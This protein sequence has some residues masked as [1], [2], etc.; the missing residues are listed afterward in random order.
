MLK[1][2]SDEEIQLYVL[3]KENCDAEIIEHIHFCTDCKARS[4]VYRLLITGIKE[5]PAPAFDFNLSELVLQQLPVPSAKASTDK[6]LNW[7]FISVGILIIALASYFFKNNFVT[8]FKGFDT[9]ILIYL[10]VVTVIT[11]LAWL[12]LDVYKEYNKEM[13]LLDAY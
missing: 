1:H 4:E 3:S 7:I 6:L 13:K 12:M 10:V 11:V 5:Q 9:T 8:L 2:L